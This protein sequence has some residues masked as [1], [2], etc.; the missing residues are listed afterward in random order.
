LSSHRGNQADDDRG[1]KSE[2]SHGKPCGFGGV[3]ARYVSGGK[4]EKVLPKT[5]AF[6]ILHLLAALVGE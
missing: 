5:V 2:N 4:V 3:S 1:R 6:V